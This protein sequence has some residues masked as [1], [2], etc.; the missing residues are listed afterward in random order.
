[1]SSYIEVP[2]D[3][4]LSDALTGEEAHLIVVGSSERARE[5]AGDAAL[6][7][8]PQPGLS[9]TRCAVLVTSLE[10]LTPDLRARL[11]A[12]PVDPSVIVLDA[13]GTF[14]SLTEEPPNDVD[15]M[16]IET[17]YLEAHS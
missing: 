11:G 3:Q 4:S 9:C 15:P 7:C 13:T 8:E 6:A 14:V 1:M 12:Q 10:D 16:Y 2:K 5:I 17:L